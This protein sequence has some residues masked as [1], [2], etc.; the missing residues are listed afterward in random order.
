MTSNI[1]TNRIHAC[2]YDVNLDNSYSFCWLENKH[3]E[4]FA[5]ISLRKIYDTEER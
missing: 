3:G 1:Q 2:R 5:Q 4:K